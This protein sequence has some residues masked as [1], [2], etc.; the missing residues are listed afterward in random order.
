MVSA[1]HQHEQK[2]F[3]KSK[4]ITKWKNRIVTTQTNIKDKVIHTF[5]RFPSSNPKLKRGYQLQIRK[6]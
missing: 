3:E 5:Y 2:C 4:F 1:T 6:L